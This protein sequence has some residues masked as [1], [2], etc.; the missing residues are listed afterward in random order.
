[1]VSPP[2]EITST[3]NLPTNFQNIRS[4]QFANSTMTLE[5]I[6]EHFGIQHIPI[7]LNL[8]MYTT[9]NN[10]LPEQVWRF[11]DNV[12]FPLQSESLLIHLR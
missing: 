11:Q 9:N 7:D 5:Q 3:I 4:S 2:N 12:T 1:M 6:R 10:G 8:V